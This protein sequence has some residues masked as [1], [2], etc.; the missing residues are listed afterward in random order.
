[1]E[2]EG[3][4]V[5]VTGAA[6]GIGLAVA[7][8][9]AAEGARVAIADIAA[10]KASEAAAE[11]GGLAVPMDVTDPAGVKAAVAD[12]ISAWEHIDVLANVAGWDRIM[13]FLDTTPD[14][15]HRVMSINYLGVLATC[16]AVLPYM[17]E[18]GSGVVVNTASEAGRSGSSGEAVYSGAKG[19][20][21]SFSK[22]LAREMARHSIRVNVVTPGLTE[23]PLLE[24]MIADGHGNLMDA[25]R[26]ATPLR[27]FGAPQEVADAIL[28]LASDRS[29]FITGQTLGVAGGLVM[30]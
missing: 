20:V 22:A 18:R 7:R 6:S 19:G 17:V 2:F 28:F 16:H 30:P 23:T 24:A 25:I 27:R 29:S 11:L 15:W 13:P 5:L 9:F 21:I 8:G 12:V 10:D 3:K 26:K 1:M 4:V 14:F